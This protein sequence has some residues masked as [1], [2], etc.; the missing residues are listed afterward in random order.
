MVLDILRYDF[1]IL[2]HTTSF[3][4]WYDRHL[5]MCQRVYFEC[6]RGC[7]RL[8]NDG[9]YN[10]LELQ[11]GLEQRGL[12]FIH[13]AYGIHIY[14]SSYF[15]F[16]C[17]FLGIPQNPTPRLPRNDRGVGNNSRNGISQWRSNIISISINIQ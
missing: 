16:V 3:F 11:T 15:L 6:L 12:C 9:P 7:E 5:Q 8:R 10:E 17:I 1:F 4:Q 13:E 14:I 2:Q